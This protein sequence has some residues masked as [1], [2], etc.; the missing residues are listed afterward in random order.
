M[1]FVMLRCNVP[2][3]DLTVNRRRAM[4]GGWVDDGPNHALTLRAQIKRGR[5]S[6]LD[7]DLFDRHDLRHV[8]TQHILDAVLQRGTR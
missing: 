8:M 4:I 6:A 2:S 7:F 1:S 5:E 3:D